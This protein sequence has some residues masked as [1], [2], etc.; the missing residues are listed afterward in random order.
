MLWIFQFL[1]VKDGGVH[2]IL[3]IVIFI[4]TNAIIQH[5]VNILCTHCI[6]Q[7]WV[8]SLL[9]PVYLLNILVY[10]F[11]ENIW[12]F[13]F[14]SFVSYFWHLSYSRSYLL[15]KVLIGWIVEHNLGMLLWMRQLISHKRIILSIVERVSCIVE[16]VGCH[17]VYLQ[18][19]IIYVRKLLKF[20]LSQVCQ[21]LTEPLFCFQVLHKLSYFSWVVNLIQVNMLVEIYR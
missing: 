14:L 7:L 10:R 5:L 2:F 18:T 8:S 1:L 21:I 3:S 12:Y 11:F 20:I 6:M 19:S 15:R 17:C 9:V 4:H 16:I 13:Y